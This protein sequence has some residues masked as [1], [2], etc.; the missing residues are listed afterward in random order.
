MICV[1]YRYKDLAFQMKNIIDVTRHFES[2]Y[3]YNE[4]RI[5]TDICGI[6]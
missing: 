2:E 6:F 3:Y 1:H 4:V 5:K